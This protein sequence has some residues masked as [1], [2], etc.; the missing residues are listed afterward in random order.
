MATGEIIRSLYG[1]IFQDSSSVS[2]CCC[3]LALLIHFGTDSQNQ[4]TLAREDLRTILGYMMTY[5]PFRPNTHP[6]RDM[7]VSLVFSRM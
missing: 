5:F 2:T 7:K 4:C 6:N 3:F 1:A